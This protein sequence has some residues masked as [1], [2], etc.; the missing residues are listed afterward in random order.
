[1]SCSRNDF[2]AGIAEDLP[3]FLRLLRRDIGIVVAPDDEHVAGEFREPVEIGFDGVLTGRAV[4]LDDG[5]FGARHQHV[6]DDLVSVLSGQPGIGAFHHRS[7]R[8]GVR[9]EDGKLA[10]DR[11]RQIF[12][13]V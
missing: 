7:D 11:V 10:E 6:L 9:G 8:R 2:H 12:A 4:Q 13:A 1:M 3:L 5:A